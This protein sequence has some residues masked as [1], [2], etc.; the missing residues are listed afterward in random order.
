MNWKVSY[1]CRETKHFFSR[2]LSRKTS[3]N[4]DWELIPVAARSKAWVCGR[5]IVGIAGS[6][7]AGGMDVSL[8]L[9][10]VSIVCCQVEISASG[11]SL[12]QRTLPN[13]M[14]LSVVVQHLSYNEKALAHLGLSCYERK[15]S[16]LKHYSSFL[17][18]SLPDSGS[19]RILKF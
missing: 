8:S 3:H 4:I 17:V 13:V 11:W 6:N 19:S 18:G 14:Y 1:P 15:K 12:I 2:Q 16:R 7:P 10:L 9:S 5:R